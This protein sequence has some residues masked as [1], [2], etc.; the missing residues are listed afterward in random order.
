MTSVVEISAFRT[1]TET[2]QTGDR[3]P[4]TVRVAAMSPSGFRVARVPALLDRARREPRP[5][6]DPAQ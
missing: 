5:Y 1:I 2:M 4:E 6:R 3:L